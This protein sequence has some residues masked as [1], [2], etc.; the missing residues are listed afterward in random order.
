MRWVATFGLIPGRPL[1]ACPSGFVDRWALSAVEAG[2]ST[3]RPDW[4]P[5]VVRPENAP[6]RLG[7][8]TGRGTSL[9]PAIARWPWGEMLAARVRRL[10]AGQGRSTR[11]RRRA[12]P[13][14]RTPA[15]LVGRRG[16]A[17]RVQSPLTVFGLPRCPGRGSS[18]ALMTDEGCVR[19]PG[20]GRSAVTRTRPRS[21]CSERI[22]VRDAR[23]CRSSPPGPG[24]VP[25]DPLFPAIADLEVSSRARPGDRVATPPRLE[26]R[27]LRGPGGPH[28]ANGRSAQPGSKS[29][30]GRPN[31]LTTTGGG[32]G[33]PTAT[34]GDGTRA[35]RGVGEQFE[36][37]PSRRHDTAGEDRGEAFAESSA[38]YLER[39]CVT[40][41]YRDGED[42]RG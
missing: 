2:P 9:S 22:V 10:T 14:G 20:P 3:G 29:A 12:L 15:H 37:G 26:G 38:A 36:V 30:R 4:T 7:R 11:G 39:S 40:M 6:G 23:R 24:G 5:S 35:V 19:C 21:V 34:R 41:S 32:H 27:G 8:E 28:G 17:Q 33:E 25:H 13:G 31:H 16:H 18:G 42:S 1:E